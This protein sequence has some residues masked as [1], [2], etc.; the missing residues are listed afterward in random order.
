VPVGALVVFVLGQLA[1][2][3]PAARAARVSP[4]VATRTA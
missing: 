2:W 4:A 3:G 1:V